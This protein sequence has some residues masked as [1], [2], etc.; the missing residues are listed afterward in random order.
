MLVYLFLLAIIIVGALV[1]SSAGRRATWIAYVFFIGAMLFAISAVRNYTVGIDTEQFCRAYERIGME[2]TTA[3]KLERY[4]PLF[5][6]LCL[7]LN[8]LSRSYQLLI[9]VASAFSIVPIIRL[10]YKGSKNASLSLFLYVTLNFFFNSMNVMRQAIAIGIIAF[11]IPKLLQRKSFFYIVS[12]VVAAMFHQSA[13]VALIL[14][15]LSKIDFKKKT[16][17]AYLFA[18]VAIFIFSNYITDSIALLLGRDELY[19]KDFTGTNYFGALFQATV[20]LFFCGITSNYLNRGKR[21]GNERKSNSILQHAM[22]L[23]FLFSVFGMQVEI[24]GRLGYYFAIFAILAIPAALSKA[25]E[26]DQKL[27]TLTIGTTTFLYFIVIAIARPEWFGAIPYMADF[28]SVLSI[29]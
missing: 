8:S 19:N 17:V 6:C 23:W 11:A 2:G 18:A 5:I 20:A 29:F 9:I 25:P 22:M 21:K 16:F 13:I 3:F 28:E 15:P 26:Q 1:K 7:I 4:E 24:I 14:I 12:V 10:I 27:L